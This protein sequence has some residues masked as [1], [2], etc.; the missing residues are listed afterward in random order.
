MLKTNNPVRTKFGYHI[1]RWREFETIRFPL[2][3]FPSNKYGTHEY[4]RFIHVMVASVK[5][6][7][8]I[9]V[10]MHIFLQRVW[11][12]QFLNNIKCKCRK[13]ITAKLDLMNA[14]IILLN[15]RLENVQTI[16]YFTL[17]SYH[18]RDRVAVA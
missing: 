5:R 10:L 3:Q 11:R 17:M 2:S 15:K 8:V 4:C 14:Y 16:I 12:D 1:Y 6:Q 13:Q 18:Q 9:S 7:S